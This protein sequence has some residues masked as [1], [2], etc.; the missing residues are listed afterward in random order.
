MTPR[1]DVHSS[2]SITEDLKNG[3]L[4]IT[5]SF[6]GDKF[7]ST[8]AFIVDQSGNTKVFLGTKMEEGGILNMIGDNKAFLFQVNMRIMF[9]GN[10]NFTGVQQGDQLYNIDEWTDRFDDCDDG[11][12]DYFDDCY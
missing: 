2:L 1:L 12:N 3:I 10:G 4:S 11:Y 7:P 5:G 6:T 9:D 8:E